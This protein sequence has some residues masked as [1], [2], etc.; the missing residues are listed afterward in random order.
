MTHEPE[1]AAPITTKGCEEGRAGTAITDSIR[2]GIDKIQIRIDF[3]SCNAPEYLQVQ[4]WARSVRHMEFGRKGRVWTK[5]G[6]SQTNVNQ[7]LNG[8]GNL[9]VLFGKHRG[10]FRAWFGFNPNKVVM[11]EL[12]GHLNMMLEKGILTLIERG[13]VTHCEFAIDVPNEQMDH[14]VF[15]SRTHRQ[16]DLTWL[17]RGGL[18]VGSRHHG[19]LY[20]HIYDKRKELREVKGEEVGHPLLR[21]EARISG[22]RRF[23]FREL[24]E[25]ASPFT[26]LLVIE[27]GRVIQLHNEELLGD[28]LS[29]Q[30]QPCEIQ[31]QLGSLTGSRKKW[32]LERLSNYEVAWWKPGMLWKRLEESLAW[33]VEGVRYGGWA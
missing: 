25:L 15:L 20:F 28:V 30:G 14:L 11:W 3:S 4:Q 21:I 12:E 27:V 9:F 7:R 13:I 22:N 29:I 18:Y 24:L 19:E 5:P 17:D 23:H 8:G 32:V 1:T 10:E 33:M 2:V 31:Y 26:C 16:Q 6:R